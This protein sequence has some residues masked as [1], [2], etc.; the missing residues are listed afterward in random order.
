MNHSAMK[1]RLNYSRNHSDGL[2]M[3]VA[4]TGADV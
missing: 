2:S 4:R 3:R 1:L